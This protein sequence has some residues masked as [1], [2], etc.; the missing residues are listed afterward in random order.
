[1]AGPENQTLHLLRDIRD[2]VKAVDRK[3]DD[4]HDD[5]T[6]RLKSLQQAMIG[7]SVLGRYTVAEVEERLDAIEKRLSI[8]EK[9]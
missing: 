1:M 5:L 2:S 3:V 7:E 9:R 4:V 6:Q 8:L